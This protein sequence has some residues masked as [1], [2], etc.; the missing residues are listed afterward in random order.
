MRQM[1]ARCMWSIRSSNS[2]T[3][4]C[5][6]YSS[7]SSKCLT[8]SAIRAASSSTSARVGIGSGLHGAW[9][10]SV[11]FGYIAQSQ[12]LRHPQDLREQSSDA[13]AEVHSEIGFH[14]LHRKDV[15]FAR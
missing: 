2:K 9:L 7:V 6:S 12:L 5:V 3:F 14:R 1:Q 4:S 11:R 15:N 8:N 13:R 10:C